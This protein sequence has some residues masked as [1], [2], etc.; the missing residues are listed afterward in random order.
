[1]AVETK[2][3]KQVFD[4]INFNDIWASNAFDKLQFL[5]EHHNL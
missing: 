5:K 1:M 3:L 4:K 2:Q